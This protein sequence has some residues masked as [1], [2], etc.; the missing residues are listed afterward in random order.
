MDASHTTLFIAAEFAIYMEF[1]KIYF[2]GC[3]CNYEG[4]NQHFYSLNEDADIGAYQ[5]PATEGE[6]MVCAFGEIGRYGKQIGIK[7]YNA[8]RGGKL[9]SIERVDFDSL[10]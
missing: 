3:D 10:F 8:T 4:L 6:R 7:V 2:I 5:I 9:N 1:S